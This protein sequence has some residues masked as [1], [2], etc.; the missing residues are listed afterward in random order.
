ML[1]FQAL[2]SL[3]LSLF[4]VV[5]FV[6]QTCNLFLSQRQ[7]F[8]RP[9][10]VLLHFEH[11]SLELLGFFLFLSLNSLQLSLQRVDLIVQLLLVVEL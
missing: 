11:F 8:L 5:N 7:L 4:H 1:S 3:L 2:N 9:I 6:V 10:Q